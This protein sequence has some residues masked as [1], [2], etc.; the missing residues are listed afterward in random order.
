MPLRDRP[1]LSLGH[2]PDPDDAFMWWPLFELDGQPPRLETGRFRFRQVAADIETLNRWSETAMNDVRNRAVSREHPA[3]SPPAEPWADGLDA[4]SDGKPFA[5]A[6]ARE[7]PLPLDITAISCAQYPAVQDRYA[8]TACGASM[9]ERY[10]PKL[11]ARK[12]MSIDELRA[13]GVVIA[14]PGTRTSAFAALSILLGKDAFRYRVIPFEQIIER[15]AQGEFDA[16]LIIHEGQLNFAA[17]GLN[18]IEDLGAWWW[19]RS[20]L[21]LPLGVNMIRRDLEVLHGPGTLREVTQT[22]LASVNFALEHREQSVEYALKFARGMDE[23]L[24]NHFIEL[25]V[26]TWTLDFGETGRRAVSVFLNETHRAGLTAP[27][28]HLD[29]VEGVPPRQVGASAG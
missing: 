17:A 20:G 25:Y 22:L 18:L 5:P 19:R 24:A 16:G 7:I 26:N 12:H 11:V 2:S 3:A 23:A 29:F 13:T 15:V 9:G 27:L 6:I 10:G 8:L 4:R 14:V 21:P 28:R 1:I